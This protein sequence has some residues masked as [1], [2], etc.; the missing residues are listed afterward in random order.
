MKRRPQGLR[1][2]VPLGGEAPPGAETPLEQPLLDG[3]GAMGGDPFPSQNSDAFG[4]H[5]GN[6]VSSLAESQGGFTQSVATQSMRRPTTD[7]EPTDEE[8]DLVAQAIVREY[9]HKKKHTHV[10]KLFDDLNPRDDRAIS[11][12]A[13]LRSMLGLGEPHKSYSVF[14]QVIAQR[15]ADTQQGQHI[16][17]G[18]P[19]AHYE[20][21]RQRVPVRWE[22]E[23]NALSLGSFI[24]N[25]SGAKDRDRLPVPKRMCDLTSSK[26]IDHVSDLDLENKV[27]LGRGSSGEVYSVIHRPTGKEVAVKTIPA[28]GQRQ[29]EE[30]DK[31]L[32]TL[33]DNMHPNV[34]NFHGSF[35]EGNHKCI[36]IVLE[37]MADS[38]N[39][40]IKDGGEMKESTARSVIW[41]TLKALEHLHHKRKILHR[42]IKPANILF[43]LEGDVKVSDFGVSSGP[44]AS[45]DGNIANTF[46]GTLA[47]M[48]PERCHARNYSF[49]SDIWSVGLVL[50]YLVT[51]TIPY[52]TSNPLFAI[53]EG[54][55]PSLEQVGGLSD[56]LLDFYKLC[57]AKEPEDRPLCAKLLE[58][59]WL[60]SMQPEQARHDMRQW[61]DTVYL[62]SKKAQ[63]ADAEDVEVVSGDAWADLDA[64][65]DGL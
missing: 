8:I 60:A 20:A 44:V 50:Y 31:E 28:R 6:T 14:E 40:G 23:E 12:R 54:P 38:L 25:D 61:I 11:S 55:P 1:T 65:L 13:K 24:I 64:A 22:C 18:D 2:L 30:V 15:L 36:L 21:L 29:I 51:G 52:K 3:F 26:I 17:L 48:S 62:P 46:I 16:T 43:N 39:S 10:L 58:H 41:Q 57:T 5:M 59:P 4:M 19:S 45:V 49:P 7:G 34:I 32:R 35:Y 63:E 56:R 37:K 33:F 42:D 53:I 47:F 9:L 27:T